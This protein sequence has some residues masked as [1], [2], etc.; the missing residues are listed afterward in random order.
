MESA[1][2]SH[3]WE[4]LMYDFHTY[5]GTPILLIAF[6][7]SF[8]LSF[9]V[10]ANDSANS[11]GTSVGAGTVSMGWA[12]ALGSVSETFGAVFLSGNVVKKLVSG[13][14]NIDAYK[15]NQSEAMD[16]WEAGTAE[17]AIYLEG[18]TSLLLGMLAVMLGS[19]LWQLVASLLAWPVSG[20]H[21]IVSGLLGFTLT[22]RGAAGVGDLWELY[23]IGIGWIAS[24]L[25]SMLLTSALYLPLYRFCI[26]SATPFS[27]PNRLVYS[28]LVWLAVGF[29]FLN[30]FVTGDLFLKPAGWGLEWSNGKLYFTAIAFGLGLVIAVAYLALVMPRLI[31]MPAGSNFALTC[32]SVRNRAATCF[33]SKKSSN[34]VFEEEDDIVEVYIQQKHAIA[35]VG[36]VKAPAKNVVQLENSEENDNGDDG[37]EVMRIFRPLQV[38]SACTG[39]LAHGGNDVGNCIGPLVLIYHIYEVR[40]TLEQLLMQYLRK[41]LTF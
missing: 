37:P 12:Y 30:L 14:I 3:T 25:L 20:S 8:A 38:L 34:V 27:L 18:E 1:A 24:P 10:G 40:T 29:N 2:V 21:S 7:A 28:L 17:G 16:A 13:I 41:T 32:D 36:T 5:P 15:S 19:S 33:T 22:A 39:A 35:K 6:L 11:W 31:N 4:A 9:A 26:R 23:K